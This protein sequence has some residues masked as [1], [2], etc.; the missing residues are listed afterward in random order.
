MVRLIDAHEAMLGVHRNCIG[1]NNV[2][3]VE[4]RIMDM[5]NAMPSIELASVIRCKDCEHFAGSG[6]YCANGVKVPNSEFYCS[7]AEPK[8]QKVTGHWTEEYDP[9]A[10]LF[11]RRRYRCSACNGWN[12]YGF[13]TYCPQCGAWMVNSTAVMMAKKK[14]ADDAKTD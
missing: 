11:F 14:E 5:L 7:G 9:D 8:E 13:T 6:M 4:A 10:D 3:K 12:T 2:T 1:Q